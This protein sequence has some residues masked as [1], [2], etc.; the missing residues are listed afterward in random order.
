ME[1]LQVILNNFTVYTHYYFD[2]DINTSPLQ[3]YFRFVNTY[4]YRLMMLLAS[5]LTCMP[6]SVARFLVG[7]W[8]RLD[9]TDQKNVTATMQLLR[10]PIL[11]NIFSLAADEMDKILELDV[12][13]VQGHKQRLRF[14]FGSIDGWCPLEYYRNLKQQVPDVDATACTNN[15]RHAFVLNFSQPMAEIVSKWIIMDENHKWSSSTTPFFYSLIVIY[16]KLIFL[17]KH[18]IF[19]CTLVQLQLEG[20]L[21]S[22]FYGMEEFTHFTPLQEWK[23]IHFD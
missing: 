4:I 19:A 22:F 14:Y 20:S 12:E 6:N 2:L 16:R 15:Y 18:Q 11:R 23:S 3:N 7:T 5:C 13:T 17:V 9:G 21:F 8:F 1:Y 10:P